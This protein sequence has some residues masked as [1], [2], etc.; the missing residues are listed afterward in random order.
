MNIDVVLFDADGVLQQASERRHDAW[1][2]VLGAGRELEG[3]LA[4]LS[5]A[6]RPALEGSADFVESLSGILA[7]WKCGAPLAEALAAWTMIDPD[8]DAAHV[9]RSLRRRGV[10]CVLASNQEPHR[11]GYMSA[12]LGYRELF[13]REFY[14]CR[15]G[16]MKPS[17]AYFQ[18]ILKELELSPAHGLFVDDNADNV[19]SARAAGLHAAQVRLEP[20]AAELMRTLRRFGLDYF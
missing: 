10:T 19:E 6:E 9:V 12:T 15:M 18:Q 3:F 13:D 4:Q 2:N 20:G 16:V 5:R 11:A 7:E 17:I 8:P 14:S 1:Q